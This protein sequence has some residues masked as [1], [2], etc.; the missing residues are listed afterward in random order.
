[1]RTFVTGVRGRMIGNNDGWY[2]PDNS[3]AEDAAFAELERNVDQL[4][5]RVKAVLT[6]GY[7]EKM[8]A[9]AIKP[10]EETI[11]DRAEAVRNASAPP[12]I[13]RLRESLA[14]IPGTFRAPKAD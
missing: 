1:M 4:A 12:H 3:A 6:P 10:F 8:V 14:R 13:R 9:E 5:A 11:R 2:V 7:L